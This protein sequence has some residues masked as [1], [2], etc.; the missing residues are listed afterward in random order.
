MA[1]KLETEIKLRVQDLPDLRHTLRQ[2]GA[3]GRGRVFEANTL[4]DTADADFRRC[5]RLLRLRIETSRDGHRQAKLTSKAPPG[6][7]QQDP[8]RRRKS[9]PHH[10]VRLE[11]EVRIR[12]PARTVRLLQVVGLRPSF[13]YEKYRTSFRHHG[14]HLDLDETPVGTFLELEGRPAAI[15][16]VARKLGYTPDDYIRGTYWD[17]YVADCRRRGQKPKNM[18]FAHK[19]RRSYALFA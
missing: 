9:A 8:H 2:I 1:A 11:S 14:L 7:E 17:L 5:D 3:Q 10:K 6:P 18:V 12:H 4:Y 15:D 16:C 19:N 13:R